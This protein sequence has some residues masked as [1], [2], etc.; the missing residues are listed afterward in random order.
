MAK[1][2]CI[3]DVHGFYDEMRKA[4]DEAGFDPNDEDMWLVSLGDV[5]DR[6]PGNKKVLDYLMSLPRKILIRG[7]HLDLLEDCIRRGYPQLHDCHNKTFDTILELGN[8]SLDD[9]FYKCCLVTE[10]VIKPYIDCCVNYFETKSFV[11]THGWLPVICDDGLPMHY[12]KNRLFSKNDDWRNATE[13]EWSQARWLNGIKMA[14]DG[15]GI[16]KPVIVGHWHCSWGRAQYEGKS[17]FDDDADFS[18]YYYEDKLIAIDA[19]TA[20][21]GKVNVLVVEDSFL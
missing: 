17:E 20:H 16:E 10:N 11:F 5:F 15:F 19:C 7:N 1:L 12:T 2:F 14:H 8:G 9:D 18:P 4:L 6:G 13:E 21:T 3:S